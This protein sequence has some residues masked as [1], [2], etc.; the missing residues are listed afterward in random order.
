MRRCSRIGP[1][2]RAGKNVSAPRI[3]MTLISNSVN[4]GVVTGN[5]PS[6]GG[7]YFFCARLP[8][9]ASIGMIMKKRPTSVVIPVA[10]SYHGVLTVSPA[11]DVQLLPTD[12]V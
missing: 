4:S 3:R 7:T 12:D 8:A 9:M 2:L 1:R 5:V 10:A 6:D 11:E